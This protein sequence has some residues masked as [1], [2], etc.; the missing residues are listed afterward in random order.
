MNDVMEPL[1]KGVF[2]S[3]QAKRI[4]HLHRMSRHFR[5]TEAQTLLPRLQNLVV[6]RR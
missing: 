1:W 2:V 5:L 3:S 6:Y 4:Y